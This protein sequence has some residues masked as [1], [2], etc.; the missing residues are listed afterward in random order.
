MPRRLEGVAQH[1]PDP[2]R[3]DLRPDH[4]SFGLEGSE[5]HPDRV[6]SRREDHEPGYPFRHEL[7]VELVKRLDLEP[8]GHEDEHAAPGARDRT[9]TDALASLERSPEGGEVQRNMRHAKVGRG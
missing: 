1:L 9:G 5:S 6:L 2:A 7:G 3:L 8:P 4:E